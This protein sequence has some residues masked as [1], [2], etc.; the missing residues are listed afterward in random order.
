MEVVQPTLELV[1][2]ILHSD[3]ATLVPQKIEDGGAVDQIFEALRDDILGGVERLAL[4]DAAIAKDE[5]QGFLNRMQHKFHRL[6]ASSDAGGG[7]GGDGGASQSE[8]DAFNAKISAGLESA[9]WTAKRGGVGGGSGAAGT[10]STTS[11]SASKKPL[12]GDERLDTLKWI[13]SLELLKILNL[14]TSWNSTIDL[15][16]SN[17][18]TF[19]SKQKMEIVTKELK[20]SQKD[21]VKYLQVRRRRRGRRRRG[22]RRRRKRRRVSR[23]GG[24]RNREE[25]MAELTS[26][27]TR[28]QCRADINAKLLKKAKLLS[29]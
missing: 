23:P 8:L 12:A 27:S 24:R 25:G 7:G 19:F 9:Q 16:E 6:R 29:C 21:C 26:A 18:F 5:L 3:F 11:S 17:S 13:L 22:R 1:A 28:Y 4:K 2:G 20:L 15:N 10:A 14:L